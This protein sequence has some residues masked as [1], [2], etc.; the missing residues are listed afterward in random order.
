MK[1]HIVLA[2]LKNGNKIILTNEDGFLCY[3][4]EHIALIEEK[5][6]HQIWCLEQLKSRAMNAGA[7]MNWEAYQSVLNNFEE[8]KLDPRTPIDLFLSS[9]KAVSERWKK[10][11]ENLPTAFQGYIK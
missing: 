2:T 6:I 9:I 5:D 11:F 10:A 3:R 7:K 4:W 1:K 8:L